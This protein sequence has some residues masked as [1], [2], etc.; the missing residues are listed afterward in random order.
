M[1]CVSFIFKRIY[2]FS[3]RISYMIDMS[4]YDNLVFSANGKIEFNEC[5]VYYYNIIV[6]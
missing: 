4:E 1:P 5:V 2:D 6:I 3:V